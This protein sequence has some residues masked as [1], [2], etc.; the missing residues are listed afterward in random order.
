[1][2]HVYQ[3]LSDLRSEVV[4]E[5][6]QRVAQD[7][8]ITKGSLVVVDIDRIRAKAVRGVQDHHPWSL[9]RGSA[10]T[11]MSGKSDE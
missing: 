6:E 5:D 4:W 3:S 9:F 2:Q 1:M 8:K 10:A 7:H 11:L